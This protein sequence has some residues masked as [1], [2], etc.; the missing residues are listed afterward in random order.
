RGPPRRWHRRARGPARRAIDSSA[1]LRR[2]NR[3]STITRR[4]DRRA[5]SDGGG[6][7]LSAGEESGEGG[8]DGGVEGGIGLSALDGRRSRPLGLASLGPDA[9]GLRSA[10]LSEEPHSL[11]PVRGQPSH[12]VH[13]RTW[14]S[15]E[16][17]ATRKF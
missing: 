17:A 12:W 5:C 14:L 8:G 2:R 9:L 10:S 4:R 1:A 13:R 11:E 7:E 15:A 16:R 6:G 3:R